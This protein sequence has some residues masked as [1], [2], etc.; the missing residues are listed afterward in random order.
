MSREWLG[1]CFVQPKILSHQACSVDKQTHRLQ[2][3]QLFE[4]SVRFASMWR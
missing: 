3:C 2:L 4:R 1:G